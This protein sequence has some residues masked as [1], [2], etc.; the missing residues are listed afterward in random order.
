M[1][2]AWLLLPCAQLCGPLRHP[3]VG[4]VEE[5][6]LR[7]KEKLAWPLELPH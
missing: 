2:R 6:D 1:L 3:G 7:R 4:T 5:G